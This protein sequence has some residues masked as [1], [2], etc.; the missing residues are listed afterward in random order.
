MSAQALFAGIHRR[1]GD[2][3]RRFSAELFGSAF[4]SYG[5]GMDY[6]MAQSGEGRIGL[7]TPP[8]AAP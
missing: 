2:A 3:L 4:H 5:D 6:G 8:A 1:D 7:V